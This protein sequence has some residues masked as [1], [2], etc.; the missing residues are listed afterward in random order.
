MIKTFERSGLASLDDL[1]TDEWKQIFNHLS[2]L[3]KTIITINPFTNDYPWP[4]EPLYNFIRVWEY[5]YVYYNIEKLMCNKKKK[6]I[7]DIGSGITFFPY[8]IALLGHNV[9]AIDND[10]SFGLGYETISNRSYFNNGSLEFKFGDATNLPIRDRSADLIYCISV[11]EHIKNY[12]S[13]IEEMYRVLKMDGYCIITFDINIDSNTLG[14][15]YMIYN[16]LINILN[17]Y[18]VPVYP[19][20]TIHPQRILNLENSIYPFIA[21]NPGILGRLKNAFKYILNGQIIKKHPLITSYA[22]CL[23]KRK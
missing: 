17:K 6:Q 21:S 12:R 16:D 2:N 15:D 18:F 8:S 19:D 14:I 22:I 4:K 10:E 1:K 5:P 3:Q 7:L 20:L 13:V 11:I 23:Q 9:I